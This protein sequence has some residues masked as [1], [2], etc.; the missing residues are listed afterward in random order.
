MKEKEI[1]S[2]EN[3]ISLLKSRTEKNNE[4]I[5]KKLERKLRNILKE[6]IWNKQKILI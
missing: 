3:R 1:L 4:K 6:K 5:V 2:L